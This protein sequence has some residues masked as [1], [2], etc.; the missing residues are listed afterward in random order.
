MTRSTAPP[1]ELSALSI[2]AAVVPSAKF[3]ATTTMGPA[4]PRIMRPWVG[5]AAATGRDRCCGGVGAAGV[6]CCCARGCCGGARACC[7]GGCSNS[8]LIR[9]CATWAA[10]RFCR[11]LPAAP[12][13]G[14]EMRAA[15]EPGLGEGPRAPL[16][17]MVQLSPWG[18]AP[19][20]WGRA[21]V[22]WRGGFLKDEALCCGCACARVSLRVRGEG[23]RLAWWERTFL[24]P[25]RLAREPPPLVWAWG[26]FIGA[27]ERRSLLKMRAARASF[28]LRSRSE[29]RLRQLRLRHRVLFGLRTL[30]NDLFKIHGHLVGAATTSSFG[31]HG[32]RWIGE[33]W[34]MTEVGGCEGSRAV[35]K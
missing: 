27:L 2:S 25:A 12:A 1:V 23:Y 4:R 3:S 8:V 18:R 7:C 33:T 21:P 17:S 28:F 19:V 32:R 20:P 5:A 30:V 26:C 14:L 31:G 24:T 11:G 22:L 16:R 9:A 35:N 6:C 29:E 15:R 34:S 13:L 10:R